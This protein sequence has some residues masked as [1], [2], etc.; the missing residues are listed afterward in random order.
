MPNVPIEVLFDD[1][2]LPLRRPNHAHR[3]CYGLRENNFLFR[4]APVSLLPIHLAIPGHKPHIF[5]G[6]RKNRGEHPFLS[7]NP[8]F[9]RGQIAL[10]L[11]GLGG[12]GI[13]KNKN[14]STDND[15]EHG[16]DQK[17]YKSF[18]SHVCN[19][20]LLPSPLDFF[21]ILPP[22]AWGGPPD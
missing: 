13:E 16:R 22:Q 17:G 2:S 9:R 20:S 8:D 18:R 21:L 12:V 3:A 1:K 19:S 10:F 14:P 5:S 11:A 7:D 6:F 4:G 15:E